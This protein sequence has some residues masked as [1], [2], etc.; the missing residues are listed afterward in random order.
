[1]INPFTM[2]YPSPVSTI[3]YLLTNGFEWEDKNQMAEY[4]DLFL[5]LECELCQGA[6]V[7]YRLTL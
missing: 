4:Y 7:R 2:Q 3:Y 5:T 6:W 1:M